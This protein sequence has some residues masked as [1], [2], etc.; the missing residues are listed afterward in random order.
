MDIFPLNQK[1]LYQ[2][3]TPHHLIVRMRSHYHHPTFTGPITSGQSGDAM[4][5]M[6]TKPAH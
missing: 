4:Q 2:S 3:S 6:Q 5:Y 1:V